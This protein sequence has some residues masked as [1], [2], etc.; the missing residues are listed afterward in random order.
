[1]FKVSFPWAK[2]A[3]EMAERDY[4]RGLSSTGNEEI[5]G[6][7]W[8]P[9]TQALEIAD[10][11][12]IRSWI[13]ALLDPSPVSSEDAAGKAISPPPMFKFTGGEGPTA[14]AQSARAT[15]PSATGRGR[16]RPRASSPS[17]KDAKSPRKR[18]TKAQK[19][20][21][22]RSAREASAS[23]QAALDTAAEAGESTA[24]TAKT[25]ES[26]AT[27]GDIT[28]KDSILARVFADEQ[29]NNDKPSDDKV[30]VSVESTVEVNGDI[31]T[32]HTNVKVQMSA[33]SPELPLPETTEEMIA[34]AKEMVEEA[35]RLERGSSRPA[36]SSSSKRKAEQMLDDDDDDD[37]DDD[38]PEEGGSSRAM[39]QP[40]KRQRL[41]EQEVRKQKV[42]SRALLGVAATLAV[43]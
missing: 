25:A 16:G 28:N 42:R 15:T 7:F 17:K 32:T 6:N 20:A 36:G 10:D 13:E 18:V 3:E 24:D 41:L 23:L 30:T 38:E 37:E 19:D 29:A 5:A 31:E 9:E 12:G 39:T 22:T 21:D 4:V 35:R 8:I 26:P 1:M 43:G 2:L 27:N 11:Y 14:V 34:K 33:D 40:A